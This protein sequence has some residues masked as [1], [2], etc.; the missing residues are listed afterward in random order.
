MAYNSEFLQTKVDTPILNDLN[1]AFLLEGSEI[2][3]YTHFSLALSKQRKFAIWVAWNIDGTRLKRLPRKGLDFFEDERIPT[4][5]QAGESLYSRNPLDRGHIARRAD[6]VWG[7]HT[8]AKK[9]NEESFVFT[10][11]AP[12]MAAFNQ[13]SRGGVWGQLET[14]LYDQLAMDRSRVSVMA[15]CIFNENDREYRNYQIPVEFF[16]L[17]LYEEKGLLKAKSFILSQDLSQ[18]EFLDLEAFKTYEV[19]PAE[20]E[21][22]CFFTFD[23]VIDEASLFDRQ[24]QGVRTDRKPIGDIGE[25]LW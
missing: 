21:E 2:I 17:I 11:I 9:A 15:G 7:T 20:I 1:E 4:S 25:I 5:N 18:L 12:Q 14:S 23:S 22:K 13:G 16:K 6:L 3:D 8:E 19:A 24:K 10:N